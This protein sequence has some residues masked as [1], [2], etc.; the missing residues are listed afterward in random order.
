MPKK[1]QHS[2]ILAV[3]PSFRGLGVALLSARHE[4]TYSGHFDICQD[5]KQ[6]SKY[7]IIVKLVADFLDMLFTELDPFVWDSSVL[8]IESQFKTQLERLQDALVNQ[9]YSRFLERGISLK[10]FTVTAYNWREHFGLA[11]PTYNK[12]K[13]L[14]VEYVAGNPD[15][16]CW[17]EGISND[18]VAEAIILLNFALSKHRLALEE[19]KVM[20]SSCY[21]NCPACENQCVTKISNSEKNPGRA[22]WACIN[23]TC[24]KKGFTC[25]VGEENKPPSYLKKRGTAPQARQYSAP[26]APKR[27]KPST[28]QKQTQAPQLSQGSYF[29]VLSKEEEFHQEV[30]AELAIISQLL[31]INTQALASILRI[32]EGSREEN[33]PEEHGITDFYTDEQLSQ[34][35]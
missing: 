8:I 3:D 35:D 29:S 9:I 26:P 10:I 33:R 31:R 22:F 1:R 5:Y 27:S 13:K 23:P 2:G 6:F 11:G 24:T 30:L 20:D 4:Y 7:D 32:Q 28:P 21:H 12:R 16:L 25:F 34:N 18:N 17:E 14:S 15:L 19:L